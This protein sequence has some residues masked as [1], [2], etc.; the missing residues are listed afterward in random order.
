MAK[1]KYEIHR[2]PNK[3]FRV[4]T[5]NKAGDYEYKKPESVGPLLY[6]L[7][8]VLAAD[9]VFIAEGEKDADRLTALGFVG[10]TNS[11]GANK[12]KPEHT[13]FLEGKQVVVFGDN[14][15]R[16]ERHADHVVDELTK[17]GIDAYRIHIPIGFKDV[18]DYLDSHNVHDLLS[19]LPDGL[20]E[21][22]TVI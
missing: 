21:M 17:A 19:L 10:S 2:Y 9:V 15:T 1:L 13:E 7:P 14:D 8:Q 3:V 5:V 16:G 22:P 18:S 20:V 6:R 12:W 4:A 11:F